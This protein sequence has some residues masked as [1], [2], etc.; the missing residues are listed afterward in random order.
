MTNATPVEEQV[1]RIADRLAAEYGASVGA[2]V[3]RE[4]VDQ[5]YSPYRQARV[6]QF[7]PVLVDRTVR[8]RLRAV[9]G[10]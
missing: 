4:L 10:T 7:V 3:V 1:A 2:G 5:A 6:T 9:S 8:A